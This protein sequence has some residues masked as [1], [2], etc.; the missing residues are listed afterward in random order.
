[1]QTFLFLVFMIEINV[2]AEDSFEEKDGW[3]VVIALFAMLSTFSY[4]QSELLLVYGICLAYLLIRTF[5][6]IPNL[7]RY[8]KFNLY[9]LMAIAILYYFS[10]Q[11]HS[12]ERMHFNKSKNQ[13]QL[14]SLF[15]KLIRVYHDGI[16][17]STKDDIVLYNEQ[18]ANI[19]EVQ[20]RNNPLE[21]NI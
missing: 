12:R 14:L 13:Q 21:V 17:I 5:Y 19:F 1:M 20:D 6:W 18:I 10:R 11:Y 15:H 2:F 16:I 9:F 4:S 8:V 7:K 3:S